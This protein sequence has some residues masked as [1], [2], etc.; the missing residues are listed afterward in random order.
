M[1]GRDRRARRVLQQI[2]IA[3]KQ[4]PRRLGEACP[5]RSRRSG[6]PKRNTIVRVTIARHPAPITRH[7]LFISKHSRPSFVM[8]ERRV[9]PTNHFR[10]GF[11]ERL[12]FGLRHLINV[13]R[14]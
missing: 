9:Q 12:R 11:E 2:A 8:L 1:A 13:A 10:C 7:Y 3:G 4:S 14:R 5:E 6:S